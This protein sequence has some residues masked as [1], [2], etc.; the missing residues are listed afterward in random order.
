[1]WIVFLTQQQSQQRVRKL[2]RSTGWVW[3]VC[4]KNFFCVCDWLI[5]FVLPQDRIKV[6]LSEAFLS[7]HIKTKLLF[8]SRHP[9]CP[10][11]SADLCLYKRWAFWGR[12]TLDFLIRDILYKASQDFGEGNGTPLQYSCLENPMD[13]GAW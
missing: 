13:G 7:W 12:N 10:I 2:A 9:V 4:L 1:M 6:F 11:P 8:H 3:P 5:T